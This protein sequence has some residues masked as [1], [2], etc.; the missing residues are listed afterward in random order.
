MDMNINHVSHALAKINDDVAAYFRSLGF[1]VTWDFDKRT[2]L[3][4][5]E[6]YEDDK[7]LAQIDFGAPLADIQEDL[8]LLVADKPGTSKSTWEVRGPIDDLRRL[9]AK[10]EKP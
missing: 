3:H 4:W 8:P 5:Y 1:T 9:V 6:I 10:M 2:G 7:L